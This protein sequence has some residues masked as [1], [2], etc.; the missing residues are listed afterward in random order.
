MNRIAFYWITNLC[1]AICVN[2]SNAICVRPAAGSDINLWSD[3]VPI[4]WQTTNCKVA[5]C[6]IGNIS[7]HIFLF[8]LWRSTYN[9]HARPDGTSIW[10]GGKVS[11]KYAHRL[12]AQ[13]AVRLVNVCGWK[14]SQLV[15]ENNISNVNEILLKCL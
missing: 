2:L 3:W 8:G 10:C 4:I 15:V 5:L 9:L 13:S 1:I 12:A 11:D 7:H 14:S 6:E